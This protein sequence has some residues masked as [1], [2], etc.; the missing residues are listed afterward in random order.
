MARTISIDEQD[1]RASKTKRNDMV[2]HDKLEEKGAGT[3]PRYTA[4]R[5]RLY[6]PVHAPHILNRTHVGHPSSPSP[7]PSGLQDNSS[8]LQCPIHIHT[9][10][11]SFTRRRRQRRHRQHQTT[12]VTL[13]GKGDKSNSP[14]SI[15]ETIPLYPCPGR[16][17]PPRTRVRAPSGRCGLNDTNHSRGW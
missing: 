13:G 8:M 9:H 5:H 7:K 4:T 1:R 16:C 15:E 2:G 14:G 12:T 10:Q 6:S 17:V 3:D 11:P